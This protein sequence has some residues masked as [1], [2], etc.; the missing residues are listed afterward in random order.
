MNWAGFIPGKPPI[1]D[2]MA[3]LIMPMVIG[4]INMDGFIMPMVTGFTIIA[5]FII[6]PN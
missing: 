4:F 1:G 3:G 6:P 2:I 5:G